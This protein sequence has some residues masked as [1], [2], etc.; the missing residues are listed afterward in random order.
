MAKGINSGF[1]AWPP[2]SPAPPRRSGA[3]ALFPLRAVPRA[4]ADT[5]MHPRPRLTR[6]SCC[7]CPGPNSCALMHTV[8]GRSANARFSNPGSRTVVGRLQRRPYQAGHECATGTA[9]NHWIAH[10]N[11]ELK[12]RPSFERLRGPHRAPCPSRQSPFRCGL[13]MKRAFTEDADAAA[14]HKQNAGLSHNT[15]LSRKLW[16]RIAGSS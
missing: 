13:A 10:L 6:A 1:P 15:N 5:R 2:D 14:V 8:L 7:Y 11:A 9:T 3:G 4:A 16:L 12:C